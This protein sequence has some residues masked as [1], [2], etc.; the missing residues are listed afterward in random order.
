MAT[1]AP[2]GPLPRPDDDLARSSARAFTELLATT[3]DSVTS[4]L[5]R[6]LDAKVH[7][8]ARLGPDVLAMVEAVRELSLRGGKRFRPAL[9]RAAYLAI[10]EEEDEDL[11]FETGV[12]LELLQTYFLIHDDWMD[13]DEL[14]RGGP[15]VHILLARHFGSARFGEI[16]GVLA[17]DFAASLAQEALANLPLAAG[18]RLAPAFALFARMQVDAIA[19]QQLDISARPE[20][21]ELMHELKTGSYTVRGPV[22]LGATLAGASSG[23]LAVLERFAK[24][25]GIAFQLRDDL[26]GAFGNQAQTGKPLGSDIRAGKRTLLASLALEHSS[27]R[28]LLEATLGDPNA[29]QAQVEAVVRLFE[30]CGAR[31]EVERR[32]ERLILQAIAELDASKLRAR[33]L[34][35]LLGAALA[36]RGL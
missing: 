35:C 27:D 28:K 31:A 22:L 5:S 17:G 7:E 30:R 16:S 10:E 33:G 36:L 24:P 25:L 3:R 18:D 8:A 13:G 1:R 32:L 9:A 23:Q 6:L 21:I 19:G 14:R 26:L 2:S 11:I 20:S 4:R 34:A 29:S 15:A 12:A